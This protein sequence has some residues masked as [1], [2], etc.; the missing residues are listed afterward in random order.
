MK[1]IHTTFETQDSARAFCTKALKA[2]LIACAN[3][4]PSGLSVYK[5]DG[6]VKTDSETY[7]ILKCA[8]KNH[9]ALLSFFEKHHPYD[10]PC[11]ITLAPENV[12][13]PFLNWVEGK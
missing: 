6:E 1:L 2:G 13:V 5:W 7:A 12:N 10:T 9:Q 8:D 3:I 11:V 4:M